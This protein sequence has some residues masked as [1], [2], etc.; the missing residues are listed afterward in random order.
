MFRVLEIMIV[1]NE[2]CRLFF[3]CLHLQNDPIRVANEEWN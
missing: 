3:Y 2:I 1:G